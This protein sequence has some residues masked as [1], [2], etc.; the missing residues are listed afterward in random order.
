MNMEP[1]IPL[2]TKNFRKPLGLGYRVGWYAWEELG[3]RVENCN[4]S[5]YDESWIERLENIHAVIQ[6]DMS[7]PLSFEEFSGPIN[8]FYHGDGHVL[9]GEACSTGEE[10]GPMSYSEVSARDPIFYRW[11]THQENLMQEFRDKQ[12]PRSGYSSL[13]FLKL[14]CIRYTR[15]D[16]QLSDDIEVM[17]VNTMMEDG[18]KT[19]NILITHF[20]EAKIEH[21]AETPITY[22]RLNHINYKYQ[23]HIRN[24]KRLTKKVFIRL[25]LG[26]LSDEND[27]RL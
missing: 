11:H 21:D 19:Q 5:S 4:I 13:T 3:G 15:E 12:L 24:P 20:E 27:I 25:W 6:N 7:Q 18:R 1:V 17:S 23:I 26:I 14:L 8:H 9:I 22:N 16:F 10:D 2:E